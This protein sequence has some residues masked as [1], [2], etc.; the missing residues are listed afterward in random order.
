[1]A[2]RSS[3]RTAICWPRNSTVPSV[4]EIQRSNAGVVV[5][6]SITTLT[7][8]FLNGPIST[9]FGPGTSA[10]EDVSLGAAPAFARSSARTGSA[11]R[12]S[13]S[14]A[15]DCLATPA[16][17][18]LGEAAAGGVVACGAG[19]TDAAE[20]TLPALVSLGLVGA[21]AIGALGAVAAGICAR[22]AGC[23]GVC[24]CAWAAATGRR[25]AIR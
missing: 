23:A 11:L 8:V 16:A 13:G 1:M 18:A 24:A 22:A 19:A 14:F 5:S 10:G 17:G 7:Y 12:I 20:A 9:R 2:S 25:G 3:T 15:G 4:G 6:L 21:T